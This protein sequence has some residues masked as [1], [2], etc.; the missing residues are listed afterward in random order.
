MPYNAT[1]ETSQAA[2]QAVFGVSLGKDANKLSTYPESNKNKSTVARLKLLDTA[3]RI[4]ARADV[5]NSGGI[6]AHRTRYC[7]AVHAFNQQ[8]TI[9][10]NTSEDASRAG[11][12]GVQTCGSISACPVCAT[13]KMVEYG[14]NIRKALIWAEQNNLRPIMMTLTARHTRQMTLKY[15]KDAFR[16]AYN[17]FQR[18]RHW[19]KLKESLN[20]VHSI[21]SREITYGA[22][23]WHYHMHL[24]FFVPVS[25]VKHAQSKTWQVQSMQSLW[26][27][28]LENN[29]LDGIEKTAL[30]V[31][32]GSKNKTY[33]AK[34][35]FEVDKS[36]D[37][38]YELT[39]N[40]NKG[41]TVWDF[42]AMAHYGDI[43]AQSLYLEYVEEMIGHKWITYSNGLLDA[44]KDIELDSQPVP[45]N[46]I[47]HDWLTVDTKTWYAVARLNKVSVVIRAAAR[48]RDKKRL[49]ELLGQI[50]D[51]WYYAQ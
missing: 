26:I 46:Q 12:R 48:W 14:E 6:N 9:T 11:L 10:M 24:L 13:R 28:A 19:R 49:R 44:S 22:N 50:H 20:I 21:I 29:G 43:G 35:S 18:H 36:G 4:L 8:V 3:R 23:G 25:S 33:L 40:A 15:F 7:H 32:S 38:A 41:K 2:T 31:S 16:D 45:K 39:G 5:K 37:L 42:L 17:M 47:L 51:E 1:I 34:L 30:D 27:D